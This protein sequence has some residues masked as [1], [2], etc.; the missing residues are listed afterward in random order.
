MSRVLA[1]LAVLLAVLSGLAETNR[2]L[3]TAAELREILTENRRIRVPFALEGVIER[4]PDSRNDSFAISDSTGVVIAYRGLPVKNRALQAGDHVVISGE[5][6]YYNKMKQRIYARCDK[7]EILAHGTPTPVAEVRCADLSDGRHDFRTIRVKGIV[8]NAFRDEIDPHFSVLILCDGDATLPVLVRTDRN[9]SDLDAYIGAEVS[10]T[11]FCNTLNT[12]ERLYLGRILWIPSLDS[13]AV[14]RN[15]ETDVFDVPDLSVFHGK[16]ARDIVTSG[17]HKARGHVITR[18]NGG[19]QAILE[20]GEGKFVTLELKS[21]PS[22]D[23]GQSI[24]VSGIPE[25]DLFRINLSRAIWRPAS[26]AAIRNRDPLPMSIP[27]LLADA[28]G[29]AQI[30]ARCHG[31]TL[32]IR[33][34]VSSMFESQT[35]DARLV[36]EE[37]GYTLPVD[38]SAC[39]RVPGVGARLLLTGICVVET[40]CQRMSAIFPR[41]RGVFL[42][43]NGSDDITVLSSAPF[44]T[45]TR[46]LTVIGTLAVVLVAI[47]LWN[48]ALRTLV[49]RK[50][51]ELEHEIAKGLEAELRIHE[52]TRLATELH[53]SVSQNLTGVALALDEVRNALPSSSPDAQTRLEIATRTLKS[54]RSELRNCLWD[55]RNDALEEPEIDGAIR[56]TLAPHV[57]DANLAIRFRAPREAFTDNTLHTILC[58]IRE[59]T[60]NALRH[61]GAK[62]VKIAG[63][64]EDGELRFSVADD[65]CGFDPAT[66]PNIDSGHFGLQGVQERAE[67]LGG[68]MTIRSQTGKGTKIT[69]SAKVKSTASNA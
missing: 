23:I 45:P 50:T 57:R 1:L 48:F 24:E 39:D 26:P 67:G 10:V 22:P 27:N 32:R 46:L 62:N 35:G 12:G 43:V 34:T 37:D 49:R 16:S 5:T 64:L 61:G 31:Q 20:T 7:L 51:N 65:G 44:W 17:R 4:P 55:L 21:G 3:R 15:P 68:S 42:V 58:I 13:I 28:S 54:C 56:R 8:R 66:R 38:V 14:L 53:D 29:Q 33:G 19:R 40:D 30:K 60:I 59:L 11:G 52:R 18:W 9:P 47:L 2:C 63:S 41:I 6:A 36:L 69:I 25:T